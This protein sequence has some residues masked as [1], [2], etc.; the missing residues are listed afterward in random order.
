MVLTAYSRKVLTPFGLLKND[1][2]ALTFALGYTFHKCPRLLQRFLSAIGV[3][4]VRFSSLAQ[5]QID[6]QRH[7]ASSG[8]KGITDIEIHLPG[9]LHVI[10]EAKIGLD[11]PSLEQCVQYYPR[12]A[13]S[14]TLHKRL[15]ALV[16]APDTSF[17]HRYKKSSTKL[18][19]ILKAYNWSELLK[20]CVEMTKTYGP[21][22]SEGRTIRWFYNFLD[23]EY[24]MKAFTT[25][26]WI[27]PAATEQL[28]SNG[29]SFLDTHLKRKVYYRP[30]QQS[31]R[32]LYIA[33]RANGRIEELHRVIRI[34]HETPPIQYV[35]E[36]A[37]VKD[38]PKSPHTIWHLDDPV[39]LPQP[40]PTGGSLWQ[41]RVACDMDVL[42]S[43][44]TVKEIEDRMRDRR[45]SLASQI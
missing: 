44:K 28:C 20:E 24:R 41:R 18:N 22:T 7:G 19:D 6:L 8:F 12:L 40:I 16:Q 1:E 26:V 45:E 17:A 2:N 15:V 13:N 11:F 10:I 3:A 5:A 35:K 27:V 9:S 31:M 21:D 37:S 43:S 30:D 14:N 34:E 32:P 39:K 38:W 36:L 23:Q 42:L 29:W 33:F 25:E 4:G